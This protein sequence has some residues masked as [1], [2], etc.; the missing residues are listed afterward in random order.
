MEIFTRLVFCHNK[1]N[2]YSKHLP[3]YVLCA[4]T[5]CR[6]FN[7][8]YFP[9]NIIIRV[10]HYRRTDTQCAVWCILFCRGN[11][12][13][14]EN[15][16]RVCSFIVASLHITNTVVFKY[17]S[18]FNVFFYE[19]LLYETEKNYFFFKNTRLPVFFFFFVIIK[20]YVFRFRLSAWQQYRILFF[21]IITIF[22]GPL[23]IGVDKICRTTVWNVHVM[24]F[25]FNEMKNIS[26]DLWLAGINYART[27][28]GW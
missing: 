5:N 25:N 3:Y 28:L 7:V 14:R 12:S 2:I 10:S 8:C 26:L 9:L 1:D 13:F 19:L 4:Y 17:K 23:S 11:A 24:N 21:K 18:G 15:L 6:Y 16:P 22:H 20:P 27:T